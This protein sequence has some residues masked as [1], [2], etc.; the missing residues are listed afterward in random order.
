ME[1]TAKQ[2]RFIDE[3]MV[4][5]NGAAAAVRAGY[6]KRC[7]KEAAYE[8]LTK[9]HIQAVIREKEAAEAER[10]Q[11][12]REAA[13]EGFLEAVA[14]AQAKAD[15]AAMIAG[16]REIGKMLGFY[17]PELRSVKLSTENHALR[18]MYEALSDE[19]LLAIAG[20]ATA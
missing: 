8:L 17:A 15:P 18:T 14:L 2:K 1:L 16:W 13:I 11:L 10:L 9:A 7:A 20:D 12:S 6:S 4:D 5:R 3:Y 19:E